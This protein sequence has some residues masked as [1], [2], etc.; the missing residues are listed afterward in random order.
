[1]N[2]IKDNNSQKK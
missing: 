2:I 1:M